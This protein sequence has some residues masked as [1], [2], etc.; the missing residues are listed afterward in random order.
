MAASR[1]ERE[2][3]NDTINGLR[4]TSKGQL[5]YDEVGQMNADELSCSLESILSKS[6]LNE[7]IASLCLEKNECSNTTSFENVR[8]ITTKIE[9]SDSSNTVK[10][11]DISINYNVENELSSKEYHE[12]CRRD[13][14]QRKA[15]RK[16]VFERRMKNSKQDSENV[17]RRKQ[18]SLA[19]EKK[20]Y[21]EEIKELKKQDAE[22][23]QRLK[24]ELDKQTKMYGVKLDEILTRTLVEENFLAIEREEKRAVVE[25][26]K[27]KLSSLYQQVLKNID[28]TEQKFT[29]SKHMSFVDAQV[30][31]KISAMLNEI[32]R[33]ARYVVVASEAVDEPSNA[34]KYFEIMSNL[35][36]AT[37]SIDAKVT[38]ILKEAEETAMNA[39]KDKELEEAEKIK[40]EA[41]KQQEQQ[42]LLEQKAR[43]IKKDVKPPEKEFSAENENKLSTESTKIISKENEES[44]KKLS[45]FISANT[46]KEYTTLQ[47][48]LSTVQASYKD[49]ISNSTHTKYRFDLQKAVSTPINALSAHSPSHLNDKIL[50]L[51]TLLS[52]SNV[53]VGGKKVNCKNHSSAMV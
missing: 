3:L 48:H 36:Q 53:E 7:S 39:L 12:M 4:A 19:E 44:S 47:E 51:V 26:L 29:D 49:F 41:I 20:K 52:G 27:K 17:L 45:Q 1:S 35:M 11:S 5:S 10:E 25:N 28:I 8:E 46:L 30:H 22:E 18:E 31:E 34:K 9:S 13:Q 40:L 38:K 37:F 15:R 33:K 21:E 50:R 32:C 14:E 16:H 43:E 2:L 23:L 6:F 42:R 24:I